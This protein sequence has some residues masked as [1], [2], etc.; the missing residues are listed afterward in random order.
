VPKRTKPH[1]ETVLEYLADPRSAAYYLNAA[2]ADSDEMFLVALRNVAEASTMSQVAAQAGVS[3]ESIYRML[4]EDG[5]PTYASLT[6]ILRALGLRIAVEADIINRPPKGI[7]QF[8]CESVS[9]NDE[10]SQAQTA[11]T[12]D[13]ATFSIDQSPAWHHNRFGTT[14]SDT[15][16]KKPPAGEGRETFTSV[17]AGI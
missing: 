7:K 4:K 13:R 6:G 12:E 1:H 11:S 17:E 5:N 3:R 16:W 2:L 15:G 10:A 9:T 8:V 14:L